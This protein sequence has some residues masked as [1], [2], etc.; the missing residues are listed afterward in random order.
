MHASGIFILKQN[1]PQTQFL[2]KIK[3]NRHNTL[4]DNT[5]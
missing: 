4:R 5:L 3:S 1:H 2:P